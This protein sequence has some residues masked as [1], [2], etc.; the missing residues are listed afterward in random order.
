VPSP[1]TPDISALHKLMIGGKLRQTGCTNLDRRKAAFAYLL[2]TEVELGTRWLVTSDQ[3]VFVVL[4]ATGEVLRLPR[5][6]HGGDK[7]IAYLHEMYGFEPTDKTTFAIYELMRVQAL[8]HGQHIELRRFAAY[9]RKEKTAYLSSYNG[10]MWKLDGGLHEPESLACGEDGKFFV[11]DDHGV[12]VEPDVGPHDLLIPMLTDANYAKGHGASIE[13]QRKALIVWMFALAFPD[14]MPTKPLLLLEGTEGSGKSSNVKLIQMA[15]M[16]FE[17]AM[18]P[19]KSQED[20]FGVLLLRSPIALL[21]NMDGYIEWIADK[22]CAYATGVGFSK[23]KLFSDDEEISI[24]P[25]S[26]IAVTSRN[27]SSFRRTD[28]VDRLIIVR[29]DRRESWKRYERMAERIETERPKLYGEYLYYVNRIVEE[30]RNGAY[31]EDA[32]ETHRMADF[33][34]FARVVGKVLGWSA[35]ETKEMLD[36]LQAERD[37]FRNEDDPIVSLLHTWV[38]YRDRSGKTNIGRAITASELYKELKTIAESEGLTYYPNAKTLALKL[39]G[40]NVISEFR[41][42]TSMLHGRKTYRLWRIS[43]PEVDDANVIPFPSPAQPPSDR[44]V[45]RIVGEAD[46]E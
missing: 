46:E 4:G 16:G 33:A 28:T 5:S 26:F 45:I 37:V 12:H 10:R 8:N 34:A 1:I 21:D 41:M 20:Q 7:L 42:Q 13:S 17:K 36:G 24:K 43:D 31:D 40:S 25:H 3:I 18:T 44:I 14:L 30:I 27:P 32:V 23:R 39:R 38:P 29:M 15:L 35:E 2:K 11:D 9:N 22:V 6:S 19:S